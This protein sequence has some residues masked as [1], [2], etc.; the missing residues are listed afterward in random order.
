MISIFN[1]PIVED[2]VINTNVNL[3]VPLVL[4][5]DLEHLI[6]VNRDDKTKL[7]IISLAIASILVDNINVKLTAGDI[8]VK[9][10]DLDSAI[11]LILEKILNSLRVLDFNL[12]ENTINKAKGLIN[13]RLGVI[14]G[15]QITTYTYITAGNVILG[16]NINFFR[17]NLGLYN[18]T[19]DMVESMIKNS[20]M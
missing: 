20:I 8:N 13:L 4:T 18:K 14:L 5:K 6:S 16:D 1:I 9:S 10:D 12:I 15:K 7:E 11:E 2:G 3:N 17:N 19:R